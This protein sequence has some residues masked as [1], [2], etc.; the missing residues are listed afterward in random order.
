[1]LTDS[2]YYFFTEPSSLDQ[3]QPANKAFGPIP[4]NLDTQFRV[5]SLHTA[6]SDPKAIAINDGVVAVQRIAGS[7]PATVNIILKPTSQGSIDGFRVKYLIYRGILESSLIGSGSIVASS[8]NNDLTASLWSSQAAHNA[9]TGDTG[10]PFE[11]LF[12]LYY[13]DVSSSDYLDNAQPVEKLFDGSDDYDRPC[14]FAGWHIG[15]FDKSEFGI[16]VVVE[17]Y[18]TDLNLGKVRQLDH[19][20]TATA[21]PSSGTTKDQYENKTIREAVLSYID[22][23]AFYGLGYFEGI[24]AVDGG[25]TTTHTEASIYQNLLTDSANSIIRFENYRKLY[26]DL[27]SNAGVSKNFYQSDYVYNLDDFVFTGESAGGVSKSFGSDN[28]PLLIVQDADHPS[29]DT[30]PNHNVTGLVF[31]FPITST[32][33]TTKSLFLG[34]GFKWKIVE[35]KL[36]RDPVNNAQIITSPEIIDDLTT[37]PPTTLIS[38]TKLKIGLPYDGGLGAFYLRLQAFE[39][40]SSSVNFASK[41]HLDNLFIVPST[42]KTV[43]TNEIYIEKTGHL[44]Y[45]EHPED[46]FI[47]IY[48]LG[49]AW[50]ESRVIFFAMPIAIK[51][52]EIGF[53]IPISFDENLYLRGSFYRLGEQWINGIKLAKHE[54]DLASG[55]VKILRYQEELFTD[56]WKSSERDMLSLAMS[57]TEYQGLIARINNNNYDAAIH[58]IFLTLDETQ[59]TDNNGVDYY[60]ANL[61]FEGYVDDQIS[62]IQVSAVTTGSYFYSIDQYL[63]SSNNATSEENVDVTAVSELFEIQIEGALTSSLIDNDYGQIFNNLGQIKL[64]KEKAR[65]ICQVT[66]AYILKF[67]LATLTGKAAVTRVPGKDG[68]P[69]DTIQIDI[70]Q[71]YLDGT[72]EI[73]LVK[74]IVHEL[75][76]GAVKF[77]VYSSGS[78]PA[79]L[80]KKEVFAKKLPDLYD[81]FCK[82]GTEDKHTLA[83]E[84]SW[85]HNY[86]ADKQRHEIV[87]ILK[88]YN[89]I[90]STMESGGTVYFLDI[91]DNN[92]QKAFSFS[93]VDF[94]Q[95]LSW[96]GLQRVHA[97]RVFAQNNPNKIQAYLGINFIEG[98]NGEYSSGSAVIINSS[99]DVNDF[100]PS[101]IDQ[102]IC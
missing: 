75:M 21:Y 89:N 49:I 71:S 19:I 92:N 53:N 11:N 42:E 43:S 22:P 83:P 32:S 78:A 57:R 27:R 73:H 14:V 4:Q 97:W 96:G 31:S 41:R 48:G 2:H 20:I 100:S 35:Q 56:Y 85:G 52:P 76:H 29:A 47:A 99:Y 9:K 58:P 15:R 54:L 10:D 91:F 50:E 74:T 17:N 24:P 77:L 38:D 95:A 79:G 88:A 40:T 3:N 61:G 93:I 28:W 87:A 30:L 33:G 37:A 1:M 69:S 46:D 70:D 72:T 68:V 36:A 81:Y 55:S 12:G 65:G 62:T 45:V 80:Y 94:Y 8:S 18:H 6:N 86:M 13:Q 39:E 82:Y 84:R 60:D 98:T 66:G 26:V 5:C 102:S 34:T 101:T 90:T 23:A 64:F 51:K 44:Q 7:I 63:Y 67:G 25:A 59:A 16:Q